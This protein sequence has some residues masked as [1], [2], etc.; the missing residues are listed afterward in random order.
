MSLRERQPQAVTGIG[1]ISDLQVGP[2]IQMALLIELAFP[3]P[4]R[5][6]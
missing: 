3:G 5:Y 6:R 2:S 4:F 1:L